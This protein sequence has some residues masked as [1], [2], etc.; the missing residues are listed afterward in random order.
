[1]F[2]IEVWGLLEMMKVCKGIKSPY[3][4]EALSTILKVFKAIYKLHPTSFSAPLFKILHIPTL[5]SV[6]FK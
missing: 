1:L 3:T 6:G 2:G 4:S 5:F